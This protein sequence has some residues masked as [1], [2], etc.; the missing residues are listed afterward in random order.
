MPKRKKWVGRAPANPFLYAGHDTRSG[1]KVSNGGGL[2]KDAV[3]RKRTEGTPQGGEKAPLRGVP[4]KPS[5]K[6]R[7]LPP[8]TA[9]LCRKPPRSFGRGKVHR[10][11]ET[12]ARFR[13]TDAD[14]TISQPRYGRNQPPLNHDSTILRVESKDDSD[15]TI[16]HPRF[17]NRQHRAAWPW[18]V[19][20]LPR[21]SRHFLRHPR[22]EG[23]RE[24]AGSAAMSAAGGEKRKP[25]E[26]WAFRGVCPPSLHRRIP[27][28]L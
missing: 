13:K 7:H 27:A 22:R 6:R 5:P 9:A 19:R 18:L 28:I 4:E 20:Q 17:L 3:C 8:Q 25:L 15:S 24:A 23:D 21:P 1:V 2:M 14:S 10:E 16:L 11:G 12:P 26:K